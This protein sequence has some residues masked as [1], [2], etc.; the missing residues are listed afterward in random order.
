MFDQI[1]SLRI[2]QFLEKKSSVK[3]IIKEAQFYHHVFSE[4]DIKEH[5]KMVAEM[6]KLPKYDTIK[7]KLKNVSFLLS[8]VITMI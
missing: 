7:N 8:I 3:K 4:D 2:E 6:V 1:A 5:N